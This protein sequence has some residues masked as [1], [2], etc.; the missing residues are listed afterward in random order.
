MKT[1]KKTKKEAE[2]L[3]VEKQWLKQLGKRYK[4]IGEDISAPELLEFR[5]E[6]EEK[7]GKKIIPGMS[8]N[9]TEEERLARIEYK[10]L[11]NGLYHCAPEIEKY[12]KKLFLYFKTQKTFLDLLSSAKRA[13]WIMLLILTLLALIK[14]LLS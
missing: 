10:A 8:E 6:L 9:L 13:F 4:K 5:T 3:S 11:T 12:D 7:Y 2:I 14:Y 1:T